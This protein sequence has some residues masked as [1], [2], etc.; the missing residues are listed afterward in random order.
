MGSTYAVAVFA[1]LFSACSALTLI[2]A[3]RHFDPPAADKQK[4][5]HVTV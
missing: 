1:M 3:F 5:E 4:N 2:N